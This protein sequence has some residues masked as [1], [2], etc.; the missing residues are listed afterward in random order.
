[1]A[2]FPHDVFKIVIVACFASPVTRPELAR[3]RGGTDAEEAPSHHGGRHS[4]HA[5]AGRLDHLQGRRAWRTAFEILCQPVPVS[6]L[7]RMHQ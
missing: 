2:P 1:M 5:V 7:E 3:R 4:T 6:N